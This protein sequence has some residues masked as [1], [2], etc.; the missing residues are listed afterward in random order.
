MKIKPTLEKYGFGDSV[1]ETVASSGIT[2]FYPPQK[3]AIQSGALEG[4]SLLLAIPT[5]SGKTLIAELCMIRSIIQNGGR[6]LYIAPLKALASEKFTEFKNKYSQLGIKVGIATGDFD[7]PSKMLNRYQIIIATAEKVDSLLRSRAKWLIDALTV[8]VLDEIH[9]I[10]D[11]SR[12]P[13]LEILT[14]RIKQLNPSIQI[15]AL[16]ATISNAEEVAG[17]LNAKSVV[18]SWRPVPLKEGVYYNQQITFNRDGI[19]LIREE[20][21]DDIGKLTLDTV[22][23]KGQVLV[24]VNSRRSA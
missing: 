14:A 12:G 4:K 6:C 9:F 22:R 15:L 7:S 5:A 16:S 17:W 20:V 2:D 23:A 21:P 18:S 19:K 8:V 11:G 10:N 24:F 13:T 3:D 1:I